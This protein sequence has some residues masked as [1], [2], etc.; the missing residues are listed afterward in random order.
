[1]SV[2]QSST[3]VAAGRW[4]LSQAALQIIGRTKNIGDLYCLCCRARPVLQLVAD[5]GYY[6]DLDIRVQ[7]VSPM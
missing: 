5:P 1:M 3:D 4:M 7:D 6:R 2:L